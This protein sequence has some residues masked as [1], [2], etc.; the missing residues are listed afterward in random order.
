M[1]RYEEGLEEST[2]GS[3][4]IF[5]SVDVLN[6]DLIDPNCGGPYIDSPECLKAKTQ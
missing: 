2:K 3:K 1:Q 6:Y 4:F 5:D